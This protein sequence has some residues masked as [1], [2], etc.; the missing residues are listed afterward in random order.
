M[1][2]K[3]LAMI[4]VAEAEKARIATMLCAAPAS[5]CRWSIGEREHATVVLVDLAQFAGRV[6]R[7]HA[8]DERRHFIV[9]ADADET[10]PASALV[11]RRPFGPQPL[12]ELLGRA[13]SEEPAGHGHLDAR[14]PIAAATPAGTASAVADESPTAGPVRASFDLAQ[15]T[16]ACTDIDALLGRLRGPVSIERPGLP[17]LLVEPGGDS[18]YCDAALAEL[19][20]YFLDPVTPREC[21]PLGSAQAAQLRATTAAH[22]LEQLRWLGALLKSNGWLAPHL[23]PGGAYRIR[24]WVSMGS[25]Y[26]KQYR[27]AATMLRPTRLHR[28]A[29]NAGATMAEVYDVVNACDAI[30]QLEWTP[31]T[32]RHATPGARTAARPQEPEPRGATRD[33]MRQL[34]AASVFP[35]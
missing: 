25:G 35:R 20:P 4:G 19:E 28:I 13:D 5:D 10:V 3:H 6:A 7:V 32:S 17:L 23:D 21:K 14:A 29:A 18:W 16:R 2:T 15:R 34:L 22:P 12:F 11:L 1:H 24:K 26:R 27:I 30:G 33:R 9:V 8:M 31:R